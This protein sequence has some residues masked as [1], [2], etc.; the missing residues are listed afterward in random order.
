[1]Y[2]VH[3]D[4][5]IEIESAPRPDVGAP[6]PTVVGDEHRLLLAYIASVPDPDWD[7]TYVKV[8]SPESP[9]EPIAIVTFE[10]PYCHLF[11]SPND[12]AFEGH[13]LA[14]RG[15]KPYSVSE[16]AESSWVRALERMN[17]VHP[18]HRPESFSDR[19]HYI[20]S[21][22]DSTFECVARGFTVEVH[23]GSMLAVV[24]RMAKA[25]GQ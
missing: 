9:N 15:L 17:A 8:V 10:R 20:F 7:G 19:H 14:S 2:Q 11:G 3:D 23:H 22:H 1:M 18:Y 24:Q 12:E 25:L 16:V 21:F 5:V 6:L 13:P 4:R